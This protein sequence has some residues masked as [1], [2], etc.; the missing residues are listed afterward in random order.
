MSTVDL[1]DV[2]AFLAVVESESFTK[3]AARLGIAKSAVSR[4]VQSLEDALGVRL[5]HRTT[6][7]L[8]PTEAGRAYAAKAARALESISEA[9][10]TARDMGDAPRGVVRFTAPVD[11]CEAMLPATLVRFAE[12]YPQIRVDVLATARYVDLVAEGV[13]LALRFGALADSSLVA[14]KLPAGRSVLLA[15]KRYLSQRGT[16]KRLSDLADHDFVLFRA[17]SGTM[18]IELEGPNGR[19][20][21]EVHGRLGGDDLSFVRRAAVEGA[22]IAYMPTFLVFDALVRGELVLVLPK[23]ASKSAV[24]HLVF[25]SAR[26]LPKRVQLLADHVEGAFASAIAA[27]DGAC[28]SRGRG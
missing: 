17:P 10:E 4:R 21:V 22:G 26:F 8:Q 15:S 11:L 16:P 9:N 24:G 12:Q 3:A 19:E 13:D 20:A 6:R 25:P 23:Y 1:H 18:R 28:K 5:L 14:R 27:A 7:R 2:S